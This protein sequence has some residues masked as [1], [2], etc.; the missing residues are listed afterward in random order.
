M[1][2]YKP[3]ESCVGTVLDS[4]KMYDFSH[5]SGGIYSK[6]F[7]VLHFGELKGLFLSLQGDHNGDNSGI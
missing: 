7:F 3:F 2:G 1:R 6:Q 4:T 5:H